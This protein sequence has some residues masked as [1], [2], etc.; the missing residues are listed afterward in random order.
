MFDQMRMPPPLWL[1]ALIAVLAG[2]P[3]LWHVA[4][5]RTRRER[6]RH[7]RA[8]GMVSHEM[9]NSAQAMLMSI[10][11][12]G[13]SPLASGQRELLAAATA[14]GR[15][16]RSLLN[17]SLDFSRLAGGGFKPHV[18][19][20]DVA[21][22]STAAPTLRRRSHSMQKHCGRLSTTCLATR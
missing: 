17:R 19:A 16:L 7:A 12:L 11:L 8:A 15:S 3:I 2:L 5:R 1:L 4:A 9:R 21:F 6:R 10:D 13:R 20:C 14:A 22:D 18:G